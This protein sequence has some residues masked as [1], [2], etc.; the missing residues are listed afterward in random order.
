MPTTPAQP[1]SRAKTGPTPKQQRPAKAT[2]A[3]EEEAAPGG[4]AP[5]SEMGTAEVPLSTGGE[6]NGRTKTLTLRAPTADQYMW[7]EGAYYRMNL[8][9]QAA[10]EGEAFD[11]ADRG[12]VFSE[13]RRLTG[14]FLSPWEADWAEDA[15]SRGEVQLADMWIAMGDAFVQAGGRIEPVGADDDADI[16]IE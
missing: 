13:L 10:N 2:T 7:A 1:G 9:L 11:Q 3:A 15:L 12:R 16:V 5:G 8:A 4:F 14:V 6:H